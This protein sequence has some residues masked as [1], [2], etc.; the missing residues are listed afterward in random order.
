MPPGFREFA[1]HAEPVIRKRSG[2]AGGGGQV[3]VAPAAGRKGFDLQMAEKLH[4]VA[5]LRR[6]VPAVME[7]PHLGGFCPDGFGDA[8]HVALHQNR[9]HLPNIGFVLWVESASPILIKRILRVSAIHENDVE[10][11]AIDF[12]AEQIQHLFGLLHDVVEV[13][14]AHAELPPSR[15]GWACTRQFAVGADFSPFWVQRCLE[16]IPANRDIDRAPDVASMAG[17]DLLRQQVPLKVR[18]AE[19]EF[20]IVINITVVTTGEEGHGIDVCIA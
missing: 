3:V 15:L 9:L 4:P 5:E 13:R 19:R 7:N 20:C 1:G 10:E 14:R 12:V 17:P 16:F 8:R 2:I 6:N 18:M 11:E